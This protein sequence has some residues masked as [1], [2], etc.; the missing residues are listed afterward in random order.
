MSIKD[1]TDE[2]LNDYLVREVTAIRTLRR[3]L[4]RVFH[5]NLSNEEVAG[6]W[7][8][9]RYGSFFRRQYRQQPVL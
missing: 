3:K 4:Q 6:Y 9:S 5:T 8:A 7:A 1:H 2:P